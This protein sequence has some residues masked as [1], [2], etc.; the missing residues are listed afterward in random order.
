MKERGTTGAGR[1]QITGVPRVHR[2]L[3]HAHGR[4]TENTILFCRTSGTHPAGTLSDDPRQYGDGRGEVTPSLDGTDFGPYERRVRL[5]VSNTRVAPA[6]RLEGRAFDSCEGKQDLE[7]RDGVVNLHDHLRTHLEP[8]EVFRRGRIV[9]D[10]VYDFERQPER[11]SGTA[12]RDST[13]LLRRFEVVAGQVN[14]LIKAHV[15]SRKDSLSTEKQSQIVSVAM[16]RHEYE[17]LRD[18]MLTAKTVRGGGQDEEDEEEHVPEA[19]E[20]SDNELEAEHQEA[21]VLMTR[22]VSHLKIARPDLT[23]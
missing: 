22:S 8:I 5:F 23:S 14:P 11:K 13:F 1:P 7:T 12:T 20:A 4:G 18:A 21:A 2:H 6:E 19:D 17:L 15:F 10:F 3:K 9:D 16:N